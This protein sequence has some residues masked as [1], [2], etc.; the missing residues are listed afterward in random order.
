MCF[1]SGGGVKV[2]GHG[3]ERKGY[4]DMVENVW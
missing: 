2:I 1:V 4:V 3:G